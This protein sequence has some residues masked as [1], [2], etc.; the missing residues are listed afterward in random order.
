M[1]L[2]MFLVI[3]VLSNTP[4]T[5]NSILVYISSAR[6]F[7]QSPLAIA[8]VLQ[9]QA[10]TKFDIFLGEGELY[11]AKDFLNSNLRFHTHGD[12]SFYNV[13]RSCTG[14]ISTAGHSLLSEAMYLGIPVY[15]IPVEPYEQQM[16]AYVI[17]QNGFGISHPNLDNER[18]AYFVENIKNFEDVIKKDSKILLRG[19]GQKEIID[20]LEHKFL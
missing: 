8:K 3:V 20:F 1:I 13:L 9:K 19:Q 10:D 4:S 18:L 16:N 6:P 17:D 5:E 12:Q 15:A 14:I 2:L 7:S 11:L